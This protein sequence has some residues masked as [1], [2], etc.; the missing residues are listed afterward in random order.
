MRLHFRSIGAL[1]VDEF[2]GAGCL[3]GGAA[4]GDEAEPVLRG[5]VTAARRG[6]STARRAVA[7]LA[8]TAAGSL[9]TVV[10]DVV[11]Q[12]QDHDART[13]SLR[14]TEI[15][16]ARTM[17]DRDHAAFVSFL[18]DEA[19]FFTG[20]EELRG[21]DAVA[22]AWAPYFES[23][24]PPFS[25]APTVVT[26]VDSG[27]LGLTSGPVLDPEGQRIATFSSVWRQTTAGEWRIVLDRGYRWC[28]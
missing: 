17:A 28:E 14:R 4:R 23:D 6:Q 15:A 2:P 21:R 19:I 10:V 7:W 16:F 9:V 20:D 3:R 13:E 11:A 26:V 1:R 18:D 25:W 24:E 8:M 22:D 27:T 5:P 12:A